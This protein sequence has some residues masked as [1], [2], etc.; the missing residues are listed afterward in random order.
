MLSLNW[1]KLQRAIVG[2]LVLTL[3]VVR[4]SLTNA[5]PGGGRGGPRPAFIPEDYNDKQH[6]M[7][8]L[9]IKTLRPGKNG[10]NQTG[11]G[12]DEATANK[13]VASLPD[14]MTMNDGTKVTTPE[15]WR[16]RRAEIIEDYEREVYG[17]VPESVPQVTWEV[18]STTEGAS[19]ET[20][21]LTKT[22]VGRVDNSA[23]PE[24]MVNIQAS[25]TVPASATGPVPIIIEFGGGGGFGG[26]GRRGG[27]AARGGQPAEDSAGRRSAARRGFGGGGTPWTQQAAS[28]G[29]G[30]GYLNPNSIQA[31]GGGNSLRQGIIGLANRGEPRTPEQWGGLRAWAWGVSRLIDYFEANPDTKVDPKKVGI[32]G[33]SR[34]GKA[35]LVAAAL[36]ERVAVAFVASSG[37]GGAKL[38]RRDFGEGVENLANGA[39]YWFAGNFMKYAASEASFGSKNADDIPVDAHELIALCAP[40]P[41]FISYGVENPVSGGIP[42]PKWVDAH[43]SFMATILAGPAY[44]VL[45]KQDLGITGDFRTEPMPP[46][47]R[48]VGGELAW[49]QHSGGHTSAPNFPTFFEW[50]KNY[51]PADATRP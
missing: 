5:Q 48:L 22:L 51:I 28:H 45:G 49:R 41:C 15:Q 47:D 4:P 50:V 3:A 23:F 17:R 31:D 18:T 40:R 12:F 19:G 39:Y 29:W 32:E 37:G 20:P 6:M 30:Y 16:K 9:G 38:H 8:V 35:A 10:N 36:D 33:V 11:E 25:F 14:L 42:D 2:A 26:R 24:I 21:T 44:R 34:Y 27:A 7:D 1:S 46:V 43:G 13:W